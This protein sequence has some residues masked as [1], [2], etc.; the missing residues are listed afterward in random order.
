MNKNVT[1][2]TE[3]C[4][5]ISQRKP[6]RNF[7]QFENEDSILHSLSILKWTKRKWPHSSHAF[8]VVVKLSNWNQHGPSNEGEKANAHTAWKSVEIL[9]QK[10][11]NGAPYPQHLVYN[12]L[13]SLEIVRSVSHAPNTKSPYFLWKCLRVKKVRKID[14]ST[15]IL[16]VNS[17]PTQGIKS[18][19][20][21]TA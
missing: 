19:L 8:L 5:N 18:C 11:V 9:T 3:P 16:E 6:C 12:V 15:N 21:I 13:H 1:L 20:P 4:V 2:S 17:E 10:D 7:K 14:H